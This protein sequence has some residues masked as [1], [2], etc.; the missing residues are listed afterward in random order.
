MKARIF[1]EYNNCNMKI[2]YNNI[3]PFEG[4]AAINL[5]GIFFVR[6]NVII[7]DRLINHESIHTAQMKETLFIFFY[8]WYI[9]EWLI[10][11][12]PYGGEAYYN[13]SFEREAY[14]NAENKD[15]LK[16]RKLFSF[17]KYL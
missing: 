3:I 1:I 13:L 15:Y 12:V 10:K 8:I 2:V 16:N 9:I 11:F 7:S 4:F 17:L 5:F 6:K 14:Q